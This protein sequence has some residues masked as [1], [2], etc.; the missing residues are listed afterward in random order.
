[1]TLPSPQNL[2]I[3][4]SDQHTRSMSG[5]YGHPL[6]R[7]PH[8][9]ALAARGTRFANAYTNCPICVPARA[10]MATGRFVHQTRHW[11]NAAPYC[12]E[13]VSW[14]HRVRDAGR[15]ADSIG[16]LHFRSYDDD[17]GFS[18]EIE[19]LH[20]VEGVGDILGCIRDNAPIRGNHGSFDTAGPGESTYID[21]DQRNADNAIKWI[22]QHANDAEPWVLFLSF[23]LPHPPYICPTNLYDLYPHGDL[24]L[25]PQWHRDDWPIHPAMREFRRFFDFARG[26]DEAL[27]RHLTATYYGMITCLDRR[28]GQVFDAV[29]RC[30]L[31]DSTRVLYT[32]DHGESM[33][34]RGIFGKF[35]MYDESAAVPLIV[36]GPDVARGKVV[37]TP[38]SLVDLFPTVIDGIGIET[39]DEDAA[40]PGRSLWET[41]SEAD[42]E[43]L[44][45]SEYHAVGSRAGQYMLCDGHYKYV[46]YT[47]QP[48]QLFDLHQDPR[49]LRDI[50]PES[51][52]QARLGKFERKLRDMVNPEETDGRAKADQRA[53]V[54]AFG[55]EAAVLSRGD[56]GNS[57]APGET[58][59]FVNRS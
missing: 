42:H 15:Q 49:E 29:T 35:T 13:P 31:E 32:S 26:F 24:R 40:L 50:A 8:L 6:I 38:V 17:N 12:G 16:K 28:I 20:V 45:F 36:A 25:Q 59:R 2:I 34:A 21:Y 9:D 58:P 57:P 18:Q 48:P 33:G 55:G 4:L 56:F 10:S 19:P 51:R 41:A 52:H 23:V 27:I 43:A 7:T 30:G 22:D 54:E 3:I 1:M 11:D 5:C 46:Y 37:N 14:H 44:V 47:G 39:K 53:R